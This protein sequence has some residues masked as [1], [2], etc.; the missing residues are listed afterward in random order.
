MPITVD[1]VEDLGSD[2]YVYGHAI[3][4][5]SS[6]R[7]VVRTSGRATPELGATSTSSHTPAGTTRCRTSPAN[8]SDSQAS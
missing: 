3:L 8:A 5:G 1:L 6:A 7:F 4:E 2:E